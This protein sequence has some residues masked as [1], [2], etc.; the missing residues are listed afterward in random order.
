MN[1]SAGDKSNLERPA[2]FNMGKAMI[3]QYWGNIGLP[4][5]SSNAAY[6]PSPHRAEATLRLAD[7]NGTVD[8]AAYSRSG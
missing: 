2:V 6:R 4:V 5:R 3:F 1:T 7:M 8:T